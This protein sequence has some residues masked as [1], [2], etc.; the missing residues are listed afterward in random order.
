[1]PSPGQLSAFFLSPRLAV[2]SRAVAAIAGGYALAAVFVALFALLLPALFS[3]ERSAAVMAATMTSF[4]LHALAVITA[5]ATR[6]A[7][8][9]WLWLLL[10]TVT[11]AGLLFW[12]QR[13]TGA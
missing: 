8:R 3:M 9:A 7:T 13:G 11:M 1:M 6:S 5:F 10:P 2:A 12:L 4:A